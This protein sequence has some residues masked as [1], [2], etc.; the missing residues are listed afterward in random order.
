[1]QNPKRSWPILVL[2][3]LA[4]FIVGILATFATLF[5][6]SGTPAGQSLRNHLGLQNLQTFNISTT[7]TEKV[8]VEESSAIIKASSDVSP[9]VVSITSATT[10]N[11]IFGSQTAQTSGSGFILTS[12]GLIA[13]NKHVVTGG[14]NFVVTTSDGKTY[15]GQIAATDPVT[16]LAFVKVDA[17]GLPVVDLGDS[18]QAQVGQWV[19]AIG[20]ALGE[21]QNTVTVGVISAKNRQATPSD[22]SGNTE[23]LDGLLQTDAAINS[24]NSGGPLLNIQG[25]VMGINTAIVGNAQ[26]I[27]FAIPSNEVQKDLDSYRKNGKIIRPYIGVQY[28]TVTELIAKDLNL[29]TNQGAL[30]YNSSGAAVVSGSPADKA[31]LKQGDVITKI[32][33]DSVTEASPLDQII[34]KYNPGDKISVT[35]NRG[36]KESTVDLTLGS[37][38]Q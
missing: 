3:A 35:I 21:Y 6:L 24:G 18:D 32:N 14:S 38:G 25:Q 10:V 12:D 29:S 9:S 22:S 34:R 20:N 7:K 11:T 1:M 27:G 5:F 4:V 37:V 13:T 36:G 30:V 8:V 2:G 19:I 15:T 26:N 17:K 28:Q 16:D 33:N 23:T 31:G